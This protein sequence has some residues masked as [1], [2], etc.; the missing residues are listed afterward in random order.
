ELG[1][2]TPLTVELKIK[3]NGS[4]SDEAATVFPLRTYTVKTFARL[5][6]DTSTVQLNGFFVY[7]GMQ[8][9]ATPMPA[10]TTI[11]RRPTSGT[12]P[13]TYRSSNN[14]GAQVDGNGGVIGYKNGQATI[15]VSDTFGQTVSYP[16]VRS[17]AWK[18]ATI[19]SIQGA[20]A[21]AWANSVGAN[22]SFNSSRPDGGTMAAL[23]QYYVM[24]IG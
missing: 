7:T 8:R 24:A 23:R 19:P 14:A 15:E 2:N 3:F 18:I 17:N 13:F 21:P 10:G 4:T 6:I 1:N 5:E 9:N 12:P 16:I 22:N 11:T 20:N